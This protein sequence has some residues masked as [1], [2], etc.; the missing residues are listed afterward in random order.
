M[1]IHEFVAEVIGQETFDNLPILDLGDRRGNTDY[2]DFVTPS[3]MTA[4]IMRGVDCGSRPFIAFRYKGR[5]LGWPEKETGAIVI[6]QRYTRDPHIWVY[7]CSYINCM[8]AG[9]N[10]MDPKKRAFFK[11]LLINHKLSNSRGT[12]EIY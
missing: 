11:E 5:G 8:F 2:I 12:M 10:S 4:P 1:S 6:F 7:G 3:M 9:S